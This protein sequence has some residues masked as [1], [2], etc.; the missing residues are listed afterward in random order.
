MDDKAENFDPAWVRKSDKK[1]KPILGIIQ[2]GH[3]RLQ[4]LAGKEGAL[5][6]HTGHSQAE[7]K[8]K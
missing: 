4:A 2:G 7:V 3:L 6:P 1:P 8:V 5:L